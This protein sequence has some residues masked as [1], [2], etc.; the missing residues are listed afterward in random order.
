MFESDL[1]FDDFLENFFSNDP[2]PP[3]TM[4]LNFD[5]GSDVAYNL[6]QIAM[7]GAK[8]F[9]N[10]ELHMLTSIEISKLMPYF[11]AIGFSINYTVENGNYYKITFERYKSSVLNE[12]NEKNI[13]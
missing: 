12:F 4:T 3:N 7:Y 6:G 13:Y 11:S 8:R 10:K 2:F 9:F 5:E 1:S